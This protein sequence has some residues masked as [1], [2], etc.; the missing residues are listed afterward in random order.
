MVTY[1]MPV[2]N[3]LSMTYLPEHVGESRVIGLEAGLSGNVAGNGMILPRMA[4]LGWRAGFTAGRPL[5]LYAEGADVGF[6]GGAG[7]NPSTRSRG[8]SSRK[9]EGILVLLLPHIGGGRCASETD[10]L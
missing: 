2:S 9:R 6:G 5:S 4:S 10:D 1:S 7:D 3:L 8:T